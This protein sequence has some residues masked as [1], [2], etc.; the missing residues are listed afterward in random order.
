MYPI[1]SHHRTYNANPLLTEKRLTY[2][3][4]GKL[5][6]L[7]S[8]IGLGKKAEAAT[9]AVT[10]A[11]KNWRVGRWLISPK[12]IKGVIPRLLVAPF[13][14]GFVLPWEGVKAGTKGTANYVKTS[15]YYEPAKKTLRQTARL[16]AGA[17]HITGGPIMEAGKSMVVRLPMYALHDNVMTGLRAIWN[18]PATAIGKTA[19]FGWEAIKA[20][21]NIPWQGLKG[22]KRALW[23]APKA[24]I[25]RDHR[26][27]LHHVISP[28]TL[29]GKAIAQPFEAGGRAV[30]ATTGEI[31]LTA[32]SYGANF[33]RAALTP[34]E[35]VTNGFRRQRKG[36][37]ILAGVGEIFKL[38]NAQN[39][40][41]RTHAIVNRPKPLAY[42]F[43]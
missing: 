29:P 36:L 24:M 6:S 7:G 35:S 12:S 13:Y 43:G 11:P 22:L 23:N 19:R 14:A 9:A 18:I 32:L 40:R 5:G 16:P 42:N 4:G 15:S 2:K 41:E 34:V 20:P 37:K 8:K 25:A 39:M 26:Q 3:L 27:A 1:T 10:E 33:T 17:Y 21:V 38:G 31:G 30:G 28:A